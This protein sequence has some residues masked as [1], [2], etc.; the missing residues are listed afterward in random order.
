MGGETNSAITL[1]IVSQISTCKVWF[2]AQKVNNPIANYFFLLVFTLSVVNKTE[3]Q[4]GWNSLLATFK[5]RYLLH[6]HR[7]K[8]ECGL[9]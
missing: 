5:N 4:L 8:T 3:S 2:E 9:I 1:S 6:L 7:Y